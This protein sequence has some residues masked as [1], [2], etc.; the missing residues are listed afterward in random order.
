[1]KKHTGRLT[2][3]VLKALFMRPTT[4]KYAGGDFQLDDRCRGMIQYDP[5]ECI[6]CG[7]CMRDCPT[8]ALSVV[9]H[10]TREEKQME[11]N[12]N[13]GMCIFCGQCVDSCAKH[14]LST[15]SR[16]DLSQFTKDGLIIRL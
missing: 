16:V 14:C 8:G 10:G 9:N 12:L 3:T 4:I 2:G 7:L 1:M 5:T 15:T 11:A 6:A 13:V